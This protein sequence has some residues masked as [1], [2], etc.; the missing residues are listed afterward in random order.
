MTCGKIWGEPRYGKNPGHVQRFTARPDDVE[1]LWARVPV[2][3]GS[4]R[5]TQLG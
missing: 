3:G 4:R 1:W 5:E 2:N